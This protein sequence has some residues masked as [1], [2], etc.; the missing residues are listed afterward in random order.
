MSSNILILYNPSCSKCRLTLELLQNHHEQPEII[1]Y[2]D[3]P[4]SKQQLIDIL[5]MLK[6]TPRELMRQHEAPYKDLRLDDESL[7]QEDLIDAMI[8]HPV[9]IERPVVVKNGK[10]AIGRPPERVLG[11]L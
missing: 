1:Q 7:S 3:T 9:L 4:P 6:L 11:I 5:D 2:L 8:A 10:A